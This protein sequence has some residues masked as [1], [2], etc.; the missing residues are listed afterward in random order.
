[1]LQC[2]AD[3]K[4]SVRVCAGVSKTLNPRTS[5]FMWSPKPSCGLV[6]DPSCLVSNSSLGWGLLLVVVLW[7]P[8]AEAKG[9]RGRFRSGS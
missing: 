2:L 7:T 1:M 6:S 9:W 4:S 3:V 8:A 5:K